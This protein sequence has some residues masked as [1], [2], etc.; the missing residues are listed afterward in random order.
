MQARTASRPYEALALHRWVACKHFSC[1][2]CEP[3]FLVVPLLYIWLTDIDNS[4]QPIRPCIQISHQRGDRIRSLDLKNST[5]VS[6]I[7]H[8]E[9][10]W[11]SLP[12]ANWA[13]FAGG[14]PCSEREQTE[15]TD[16]RCSVYQGEFVYLGDLIYNN[17]DRRT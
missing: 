4:L 17:Y 5:S 15:L 1:Q 7:S 14:Q 3:F 6:K 8:E 9:N 12:Q 2:Q 16:K 10:K 11:T 13:S